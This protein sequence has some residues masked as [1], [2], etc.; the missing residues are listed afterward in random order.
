MAGPM[1][2]GNSLMIQQML[3]QKMGHQQAQDGLNA[4][5]GIGGAPD[6]GGGNLTQ[7]IG[8]ALGAANPIAGAGMQALG[9]AGKWASDQMLGPV[10]AMSALGNSVKGLGPRLA[11]TIQGGPGQGI[12][13]A[14][15]SA[16]NKPGI[17]GIE[18]PKQEAMEGAASGP[19]EEAG[20][21]HF[22]PNAEANALSAA[23]RNMPVTGA[24]RGMGAQMAPQML[25]PV[26]PTPP[27]GQGVNPGT[28]GPG[29]PFRSEDFAAPVGPN[30]NKQRRRPG[31]I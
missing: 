8:G 20:E 22:D 13:G 29:A 10:N 17:G 23:A 25:P 14:L 30:M 26:Q 6:Q 28:A 27:M 1:G 5:T 12:Q 31:I 16:M 7:Q 11:N 18:T 2:G 9:G 4:P 15:M 21:T 24:G 19:K 3:R